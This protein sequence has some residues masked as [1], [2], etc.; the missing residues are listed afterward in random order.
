M[1]PE[2]SKKMPKIIVVLVVL[3]IGLM[4][5]MLLSDMNQV[6]DFFARVG[7]SLPGGSSG[8]G[9]YMPYSE[10]IEKEPDKTYVLFFYADWSP[11]SR[12][13]DTE[14]IKEAEEKRLPDGL[15]VLK[16]PFDRDSQLGRQYNVSYQH[17]LVHIDHNGTQ[18]NKWS[19][20]DVDLMLQKLNIEVEDNIY[21]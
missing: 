13:L 6:R 1:E 18:L 21:E 12:D 2:S 20:G 14:L 9:E 4:S 16:V 10:L 8:R 17:T 5:F 15:V 7:I 11:S 3:I 19:G